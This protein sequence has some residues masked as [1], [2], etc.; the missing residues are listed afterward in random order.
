MRGVLSK[1]DDA[2]AML[3]EKHLVGVFFV[4]FIKEKYIPQ[5]SDVR[6][7]VVP[8]GLMGMM[9]NK[10]GITLH[11][12]VFETSFCFVCCH[13]RPHRNEVSGR[14]LDVKTILDRTVLSPQ[15]D[16]LRKLNQQLPTQRAAHSWRFDECYTDYSIL[17]HTDYVFW[18]GDMNYRI[19]SDKDPTG[20]VTDERIFQLSERF[21]ADPEAS[22][23]LL[24]YDQLLIECKKGTIFNDF[25][26]GTL[27]FPPTYKYQPGTNLYEKRPEKKLR[28]P[29][30]CDRILYRTKEFIR[31]I[32]Y[33]NVYI[34][35][36]DHMPVYSE[37]QVEVQIVS[38]ERELQVNAFQYYDYLYQ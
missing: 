3:I 20:V 10:S 13:L 22:S 29:A 33:S 24:A 32:S 8:L 18:L 31:Q 34:L 6:F 16:T 7:S 35:L 9:G 38:S 1:A 28:I 15:P 26:E 37:F 19:N 14:N 17:T 25:V 2:Y 36:S 5:V 23:V 4:I 27:R 21:T 12:H 30:W 11:L